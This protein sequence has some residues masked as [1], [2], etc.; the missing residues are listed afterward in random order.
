MVPVIGSLHQSIGSS[1]RRMNCASARSVLIEYA[2]FTAAIVSKR[3]RALKVASRPRSIEE[4]F[5]RVRSLRNSPLSMPEI[6]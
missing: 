4:T 6:A 5:A 3:E 2:E 1:Q